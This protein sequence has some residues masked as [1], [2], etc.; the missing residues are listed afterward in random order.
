[1]KRAAGW[2]L[3]AVRAGANLHAK[4]F[5]GVLE[6]ARWVI[7]VYSPYIMAYLEPPK[8]L[9]ELQAAVKTPTA[10]TDVHHIVEQ[11]AAAEAGF[12]PEM[13]EGPENLVRISRLKHWE[14]SGW[15]QRANDEYEGLSPRGFLKDKSWAERQRVGLKALVKHVILKP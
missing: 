12:P 10:G 7:D 15:Y 6:G 8:T 4:L 1:M 13:I 14:I 3:R 9:A 2:L 11:T 5:I